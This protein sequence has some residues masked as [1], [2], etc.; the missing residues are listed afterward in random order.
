M[1]HIH[2][3]CHE[4]CSCP[5]MRLVIVREERPIRSMF[6]ATSYLFIR[7]CNDYRIESKSRS[8]E[9]RSV[10]FSLVC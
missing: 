8:K 7:Q 2:G 10:F 5:P 9:R 1:R 6:E 3:G 4:D